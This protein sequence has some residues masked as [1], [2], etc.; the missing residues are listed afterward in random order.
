[1]SIGSIVTG[2][3]P[4]IGVAVDTTVKAI[5]TL[6]FENRIGAVL[7]MQGDVILGLV[8]ERDI[9]AGLHTHGLAIMEASAGDIMSSPVITL[10]PQASVAEAMGVMTNRRVRH[11]H[12]RGR[13]DQSNPGHGFRA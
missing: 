6:L 5:V 4:V 11:L 12:L 7:V 1:M 3:K 9:V 8:S 13:R 10:A 2:R